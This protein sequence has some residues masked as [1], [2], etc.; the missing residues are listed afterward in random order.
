MR[1]Q[2]SGR[3]ERSMTFNRYGTIIVFV[4]YLIGMASTLV[5]FITLFDSVYPSAS[6]W[7]S[8][9]AIMLAETAMWRYI[10]YWL[11]NLDTVRRVLPG[12][13]A[14][15][16]VILAYLA[17]VLSYSLFT[18]IAELALLWYMRIHILT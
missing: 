4:L 16:V 6:F 11:R 9:V 1:V 3:R 18:G 12:F 8:L 15:G 14:L 5:I 2:S 10:H 17:A 13:L 7:I